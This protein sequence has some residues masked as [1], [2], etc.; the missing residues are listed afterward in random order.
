MR[1]ETCF[2]AKERRL[3][4][5]VPERAGFLWKWI[6]FIAW[7]AR[8]L[9]GGALAIVPGNPEVLKAPGAAGM[10]EGIAGSF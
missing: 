8:S 1:G 3:S 4:R 7:P 2:L 10:R 5:F 6:S 9:D